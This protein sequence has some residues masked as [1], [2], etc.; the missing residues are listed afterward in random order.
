MK[1]VSKRLLT[2]LLPVVLL[3]NLLVGPFVGVA[4][5][6]PAPEY[7]TT[8]SAM[9][10]TTGLEVS[11]KTVGL[12]G[13]DTLWNGIK[14]FFNAIGS[15][16]KGILEIGTCI[17]E[18]SAGGNVIVSIIV[19]PAIGML[20][21]T[22]STLTTIYEG[23]FEITIFS[24]SGT[25]KIMQSV[26]GQFTNIANIIFVIVLLI[27]II[28]MVTSV[29]IS[30]YHLKKLAPKIIIVVLTVNLSFFICALL[31]DVSNIVG[32]GAKDFIGGMSRSAVIDYECNRLPKPG[33]PKLDSS[34]NI[35]FDTDPGR[36]SQ[37]IKDGG[38]N[39][40]QKFGGWIT[41]VVN[42]WNIAGDLSSTPQIMTM[43]SIIILVLVV[44]MI[45]AAITIPILA[46][47]RMILCMAFVIVSPVAFVAILH[48]KG[49]D[50]FS[51][52]FK[53]FGR[54][55]IIFPAFGIFVGLSEIATTVFYRM[56]TNGDPGATLMKLV[57][58]LVAI[59]SPVLFIKPL[60]KSTS[61]LM[62][63]ASSKVDGVIKGAAMV[64]V[65]AATMGAGAAAAGS[66]FAAKA[67][68]A[69]KSGPGMFGKFGNALE[70]M[71]KNS[72]RKGG[73][74]GALGRAVALNEKKA[75]D[76][77]RALEIGKAEASGDKA[78]A[79][80]LRLEGHN[81]DVK[82]ELAKISS[83]DD[84]DVIKALDSTNIAESQAAWEE[85]GKRALW[86]KND[87]YKS[88]MG[89]SSITGHERLEA[90]GG[91]ENGAVKRAVAANKNK[92]IA[93][94]MKLQNG[95]AL[96][97]GA[98]YA[99]MV[100]GDITSTDALNKELVENAS[101]ISTEAL[102]ADKDAISVLDSISKTTVAGAQIGTNTD[103][104]AIY[105]STLSS[106]ATEAIKVLDKLDTKIKA[107]NNNLG[108]KISD[109]SSNVLNV[110]G[111]SPS[112]AEQ[113][114]EQ[115]RNRKNNS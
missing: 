29:G 30:N 82:N 90:L 95:D 1:S 42:N 86:V 5:A 73:K 38:P 105:E 48:P 70:G 16:V 61:K 87:Q 106:N 92:V 3:L 103:G 58:T 63:A 13:L 60:M 77:A 108:T 97:T 71:G 114:R 98:T 93:D 47:I 80:G 69:L 78:R 9:S 102:V 12:F 24:D 64:G 84:S 52:W 99:R 14:G 31:V 6:A 104:G 19:C 96:T 28:S 59:A 101:K 39:P 81:E 85:A 36:I 74:P 57:G 110:R 41:S 43:S 53:E 66:G 76:D 10:F 75:R 35:E 4:A 27:A 54:L 94:A 26:H 8:S 72:L 89:L 49:Q 37:C 113:L 115:H 50:L 107:G 32:G 23:M 62:A 100:N 109:K 11:T 46:A 112:S 83:A 91:E 21:G 79:D 68:G 15:F 67:M 44:M 18:W 111:H 56:E 7:A 65:A 55:L 22:V 17:A 88:K 45:I 34:L 25:S 20:K 40:G 2:W 51:K 33:G